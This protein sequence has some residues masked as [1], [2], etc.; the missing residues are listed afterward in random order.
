[1]GTVLEMT[2]YDIKTTAL[3]D[4]AAITECSSTT[5]QLSV[6]IPG[7]A[8]FFSMTS[9]NALAGGWTAVW[10]VNDPTFNAEVASTSVSATC[11]SNTLTGGTFAYDADNKHLLYTLPNLNTADGNNLIK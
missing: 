11:G 4:T 6:K 3:L 10:R 5:A 8:V 9:A 1:M 2:N 7:Q